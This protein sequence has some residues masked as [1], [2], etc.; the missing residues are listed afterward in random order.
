MHLAVMVPA[1]RV[2]N[3]CRVEVGALARWCWG[4]G[5]Q[6]GGSSSP[7][8]GAMVDPPG[9][10]G[11][12]LSGMDSGE[13]LWARVSICKDCGVLRHEVCW[14]PSALLFLHGRRSQMKRSLLALSFDRLGDGVMQEKCFYAFLCSHPRFLCSTGLLELH[15]T[16]EFC[17]SYFPRWVVVQLMFLRGDECW[18]LQSCIL[19]TSLHK[20]SIFNL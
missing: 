18:K 5:G 16:K 1:F 14:S 7:G 10:E 19:L 15:C 20:N 3:G 4:Q 17:Q 2:R 6:W 8:S 12:I 9:G 11:S 13:L